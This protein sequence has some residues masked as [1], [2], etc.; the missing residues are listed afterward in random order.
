A[1][2]T[3]LRAHQLGYTRQ[4]T[5]LRIAPIQD[6]QKEEKDAAELAKA[7]RNMEGLK[8]R[9][10]PISYGKLDDME[11]K[12][13]DFLSERGRIIGDTRSN[14]LVVTDVEESL[15]RIAKV[16]SS[17][18]VPPPQVL[19]EGKIVEAKESF[20]R[21]L[22]FKWT[23]S[24]QDQL[25]ARTGRGPINMRP[26]ISVNQG[27]FVGERFDLG[28]SLTSLPIL[29][30]L[31][32]ALSLSEFEE[33]VKVISSPRI[34][35]LSNESASIEQVTEVPVLQVTQSN[36]GS[37]ITPTFKPLRLQLQVT[38]NIT[39]D[40]SVLM[41]VNVK[42]EF[43]G[44]DLGG[45]TQAFSVNSRSA[46]TRVLVRNGSTVAIGGIYQSDAVEGNIGVPGLKDVPILGWLFKGKNSNTEKSELLIFLTPRILSNLPAASQAS[47]DKP[48]SEVVR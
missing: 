28:L 9:M 35:A 40:N 1:L 32:A 43:K 8:V 45:A 33:K 16:I 42:R 3:L 12:L 25:L 15:N 20:T 47:G 44:A 29:G 23:A 26:S 46:D 18:D 5:I 24:G 7:R 31:N 6:L 48:A 30:D 13:K 38:P 17:L 37:Q 41:K 19:I 21:S 14:T 22:G 4:G 11:K 10:F 2:V 39:S 36:S 27:L 34:M